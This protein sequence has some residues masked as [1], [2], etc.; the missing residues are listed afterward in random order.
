VA[1]IDQPVNLRLPQ[2]KRDAST[3][4]RRFRKTRIRSAAFD[5]CAT[6]GTSIRASDGS[7]VSSMIIVI[8]VI[9]NPLADRGRASASRQRASVRQHHARQGLL[10]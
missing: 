7:F 2:V 5:L 4:R 1:E 10:E 3:S 8:T 6:E 9:Q